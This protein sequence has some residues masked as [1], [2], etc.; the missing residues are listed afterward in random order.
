MDHFETNVDAYNYLIDRCRG[1][2]R[3][4]IQRGSFANE[5]T[6][7]LQSFPLML[8]I[9]YPTNFLYLPKTVTTGMIEKYYQE[10]L[11]NPE[12]KEHEV[13]T[14]GERIMQQLPA[15]LEMLAATPMTNQ[16][17]ISIS[18]PSDIFLAD[19]PCL[20]ELTFSCFGE[21]LHLTSCWRSNDISEA[22][23]INQGGLALLLKDT[24]EYAGLKVGNHFYC[25]PGAHIYVR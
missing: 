10:Y 19:P 9:F 2:Y 23:L 6:Y 16:A 5:S 25:S 24:A 13:Y 11:V 21:A 20:R 14:Y 18:Q 4:D 12:R 22:F 8:R 1:G 7:R 17:S 15:V 3:Q